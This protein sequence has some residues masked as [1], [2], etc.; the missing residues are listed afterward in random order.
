MLTHKLIKII[1]H[2]PTIKLKDNKTYI[3]RKLITAPIFYCGQVDELLNY[4]YG[5]MPFRSLFFK[6]ETKKINSFQPAS[7]INY[8]SH[9]TITRIAEYKKI[10]NQTIKGVTTISLEHPGEYDVNSVK[11]NKPYY[12][13]NNQANI[14]QY[15]KYVKELSQ[16]PNFHLLGRLAEYKYFDMDD[17]IENAMSK[18]KTLVSKIS[19]E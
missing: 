2:K 3:D 6:F 15:Q 12:P 7:I 19:S 14:A 10:N 11:F 13:I 18:F 8:P 5:Q 16:Y 1:N 9:P 17:A 4:R